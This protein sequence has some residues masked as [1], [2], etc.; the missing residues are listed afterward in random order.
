MAKGGDVIALGKAHKRVTQRTDG[1]L[2]AGLKLVQLQDQSKARVLS[3]T[4][5]TIAQASRT[6]PSDT[7]VGQFRESDKL[8]DIVLRQPLNERGSIT[9]MAN[10]YLPT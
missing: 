2:P 6:V 9:D 4:R 1:Q 3:V 10:A 8:I 5:Q 7:R